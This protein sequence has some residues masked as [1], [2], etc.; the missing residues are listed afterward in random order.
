VR[1]RFGDCVFDSERREALR[2]GK[3][4]PLPPKAFQL[5]EILIRERP[6]ALSK[7]TLHQEL[8]PD[9][10]VSDA[11]LANL[12]SDLRHALGDPGGDPRIIR[13]VQRFGY[14]FVAAVEAAPEGRVTAERP[15]F[16]YKVIWG[17]REIALSEGENILGRDE[18][19]V[20][21]ID[22]HSVSRQHARIT[23]SGGR[24][25]L[26]DLGSKNG[27][28]HRGRPVKKAVLLSDGD[29]LRIGTVPLTFRRFA[30]GKSTE[31]VGRS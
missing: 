4:L 16:V 19:S 3:P 15:G 1:A 28:Y 22:V 26:E 8:W 29:E 23:V 25:T 10:F 6:K 11:N 5:L 17:D 30:P 14:A 12:V 9:T 24:A 7:E 20:A 27:T 18:S 21:W 2:D 13:T 31:T